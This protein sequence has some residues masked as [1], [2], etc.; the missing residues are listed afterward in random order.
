MSSRLADAEA[1]YRQ[2][3]T[4]DTLPDH[5]ETARITLAGLAWRV[6]RDTAAARALLAE[7]EAIPRQRVVALLEHARM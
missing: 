5:L 1:A 6:R 4:S 3:L 2:T 7:G